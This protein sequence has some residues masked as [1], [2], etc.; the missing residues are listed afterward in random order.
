MEVWN[1][2]IQSPAA[3]VTECGWWRGLSWEFT[4]PSHLSAD[5]RQRAEYRL[6][7]HRRW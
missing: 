7:G 3:N 5:G 1:R 6:H 4:R 2:P